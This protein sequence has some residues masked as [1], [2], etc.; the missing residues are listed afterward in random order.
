METTEEMRH[1]LASLEPQLREKSA[2]TESCMK[3]LLKEQSQVEK[4]RQAVAAEE[5]SVKVRY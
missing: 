4:V 3:S 1:Q 5:L 2:A